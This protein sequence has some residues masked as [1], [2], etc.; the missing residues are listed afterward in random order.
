MRVGDQVVFGDYRHRL[1]CVPDVFRAGDL[2][3]VT[4]TLPDGELRLHGLAWTG[5][6]LWWRSD[7]VFTEEVI[8]LTYAPVVPMAGLGGD[9]R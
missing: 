9:R 4:A 2:C 3:V 8:P 7:T 1:P 6:V 5:E